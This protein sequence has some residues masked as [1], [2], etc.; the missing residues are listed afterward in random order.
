MRM[1]PTTARTT[2]IGG[3]ATLV[4]ERANRFP[5]TSWTTKVTEN[6]SSP[7]PAFGFL[8]VVATATRAPRCTKT[9]GSRIGVVGKGD[10]GPVGDVVPPGVGVGAAAAGP[11]TVATTDGLGG[12]PEGCA[13][14]V[15]RS[16]L[17]RKAAAT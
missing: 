2:A 15:N 9:A 16:D 3:R 17:A 1:S 12:E 5:V 11:S 10:S 14:G 4:V 8:T 7:Y 13:R 6:D